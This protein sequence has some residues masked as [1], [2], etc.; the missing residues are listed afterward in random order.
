MP[1]RSA[2]AGIAR[3][4]APVRVEI[5]INMFLEEEFARNFLQSMPQTSEIETFTINR[6]PPTDEV[7]L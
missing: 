6:V 4:V 2:T 5:R 1:A 3:S 7:L